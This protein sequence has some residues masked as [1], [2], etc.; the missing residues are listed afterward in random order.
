VRQRALVDG[1]DRTGVPVDGAQH[2]R[3]SH[4]GQPKR[5]SGI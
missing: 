4:I 1:D 5:S 3:R 2:D